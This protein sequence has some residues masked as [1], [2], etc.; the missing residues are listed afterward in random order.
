MREL[1]IQ[2]IRRIR[3]HLTDAA[4]AQISDESLVR[5]LSS[6]AARDRRH[7][8]QARV[9]LDGVRISLGYFKT[10][11]EAS[12]AVAKAKFRHSIG[13]PPTE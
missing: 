2:E 8:Y 3:P 7:R 12:A 13:L 6:H 1:M 11:E 4:L 10:P 5:M 9:M